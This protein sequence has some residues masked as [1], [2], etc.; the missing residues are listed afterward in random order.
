MMEEKKVVGEEGI[1]YDKI[2][3]QSSV[4]SFHL[5]GPRIDGKE[6]IVGCSYRRRVCVFF[7]FDFRLFHVTVIDTFM[8]T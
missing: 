5:G 1:M 8:V 4:E 6:W 3:R 7:C 2:A